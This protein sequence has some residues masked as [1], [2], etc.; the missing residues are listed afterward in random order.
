MNV[1]ELVISLLFKGSE[2]QTEIRKTET[3]LHKL[4]DSA[5]K[6][7]DALRDA[8]DKGSS[9]WSRFGTVLGGALAALGAVAMVRGALTAY[10]E[11]AAAIDRTSQSLGLSIERLQAWQGAVQAAGGSAEEAADRF[12]DLSDYIVDAVKFDSGPLKDISKELGVGLKDA[13]GKARA[14][15]DVMLDLADAFARVGAQASTAYGMQMSFDPAT[16]A[17]LQKGRGELEALLRVEEEQAVYRKEDAENA[18]KQQLA[19]MVLNRA[20]DRFVTGLVRVFAPALQ[21]LTESFGKV[22]S[23]AIALGIMAGVVTAAVLPA[24]TGMAAAAWA[25]IAPFAPLIAAVAGIALVVDDFIAYLEGGESA[26]EGFWSIF[27][28]GEEIS[29]RLS[30]AWEG[31]KSVFSGWIDI[32]KGVLKLW[33][34]LWNADTEG[35]Q[36]ALDRIWGGI[37]RVRDVIGNLLDYIKAKLYTLLP[38]WVKKLIGGDDGGAQASGVPGY[39]GKTDTSVPGYNDKAETSVPG[40]DGKSNL[41]VPGYGAPPQEKSWWESAKSSMSGLFGG[42][43]TAQNPAWPGGNTTNNRSV[44]TNVGQIT[45]NTQATDAQGTADAVADVL[46]NEVAQADGAYGT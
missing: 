29:A 36:A 2:A 24:L 13:R 30:A 39:D 17:L 32:L 8:A 4:E 3:D 25:A 45:V 23:V 10:V 21:F 27:G 41:A 34:A 1:A 19:I 12:R 22:A 35:V 6:A 46:R 9:S 7:G 40:Y 11:Q 42:G 37:T 33:T 44:T 20:W 43:A 28:T 38:D 5:D 15:E 18:R 31:L 14:T 26:L 16:I